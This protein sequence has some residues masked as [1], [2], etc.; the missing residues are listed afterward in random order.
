MKLYRT[1]VTSPAVGP[2]ARH[3]KGLPVTTVLDPPSEDVKPKKS[4]T[5]AFKAVPEPLELRNQVRDTTRA[6]SP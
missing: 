4:S 6:Y 2:T 3:D 5:A 1:G